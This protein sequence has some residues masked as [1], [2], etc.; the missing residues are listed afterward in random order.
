[1]PIRKNF[2]RVSALNGGEKPDKPGHDR[3][4]RTPQ[5]GTSRHPLKA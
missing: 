2:L 4:L 5:A 3:K 1:M